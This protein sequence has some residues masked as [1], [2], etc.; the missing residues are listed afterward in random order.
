M[1]AHYHLGRAAV[2]AAGVA[3]RGLRTGTSVGSSTLF[4]A[5]RGGAFGKSGAGPAEPRSV[6]RHSELPVPALSF[7]TS[8]SSSSS[9]AP[10]CALHDRTLIHVHGDEA[11]KFLQGLVTNDI[12]RLEAEPPGSGMFC[13]MLNAKGRTM[14]ETF[15]ATPTRG[16]SFFHAGTSSFLIDCH[17]DVAKRLTRHLK[18]HK[19]RSKVKLR[20]LENTHEVRWTSPIQG[21]GMDVEVVDGVEVV[22]SFADPRA[23]TLGLRSYS[24]RSTAPISESEIDAKTSLQHMYEVLRRTHG[25]LEGAEV[26]GLIPL[27]LNL[28][29]MS[30]V[31]F[32]KGC[33]LGQELTA[34]THFRG[35][36]RKRCFPV[37]LTPTNDEN[38]VEASA[39]DCIPGREMLSLALSASVENVDY[40]TGQEKSVE[41]RAGTEVRESSKG[42][43]AGKILS[44]PLVKGANIGV[45]LL[46]LEHVLPP[47]EEHTTNGQS[48]TGT[49]ALNH[50]FPERGL[51]VV[52]DD[53][54]T[55]LKVTP[56]IVANDG[57]NE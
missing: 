7:S 8:C 32:D 21:E 34:R 55:K 33:Y 38:E 13:H 15:I 19:L 42:K 25:A 9:T 18:M 57:N 27:E 26:D 35:L 28:D 39:A 47:I 30:G 4:K 17:V 31:V 41:I 1:A 45:A 56:L 46:R 24:E 11:T 43:R 51:Y 3:T 29:W 5:P 52:G 37:L 53:G 10:S 20:G 36:L 23:S 14:F 6:L 2:C 48:G 16:S 22:S 12:E 54:E 50:S 49:G 44:A 40:G